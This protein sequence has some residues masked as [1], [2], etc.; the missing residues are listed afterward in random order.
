MSDS[1]SK[2]NSQNTPKTQVEQPNKLSP[3]KFKGKKKRGGS[4]GTPSPK[5]NKKQK[6][7]DSSSEQSDEYFSEEGSEVENSNM[8]N[9]I[10]KLLEQMNKVEEKIDVLGRKYDVVEVVREQVGRI[11]VELK[12]KNVILYGIPELRRLQ[13]ERDVP[14]NEA[15]SLMGLLSKIDQTTAASLKL[16]DTFRIGKFIIGKTRPVLVKCLTMFDKRRIVVFKKELEKLGIRMGY[17]ETKA[18]REIKK[19]F[20]PHYDA[21]WKENNKARRFIRGN[22]MFIGVDGKI[23]KCYSIKNNKV[24]QINKTLT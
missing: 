11:E 4:S 13:E 20:Q 3:K 2:N 9:K 15:H 5:E 16:D 24:I 21:E 6:P 8:E 14:E 18:Q 1:E 7:G 19:L 17:D 23:T 12:R 10:D 22:T